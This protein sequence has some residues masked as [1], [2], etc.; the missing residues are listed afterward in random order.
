MKVDAVIKIEPLQEEN[1]QT[2]LADSKIII[3]K[4]EKV[5]YDVSSILFSP[6]G[7]KNVCTEAS[8]SSAHIEQDD[9]TPQK[10]VE[11]SLDSKEMPNEPTTV[12]LLTS[13][14]PENVLENKVPPKMVRATKPPKPKPNLPKRVHRIQT[15]RPS[16]VPPAKTPQPE[17][18]NESEGPTIII[19]KKEEPIAKKIIINS[20]KSDTESSDCCGFAT[21]SDELSIIKRYEF[22]KLEKTVESG[23]STSEIKA[24]E[25]PTPV[26][27]IESPPIPELPAKRN[28]RKSIVQQE[29]KIVEKPKSRVAPK[30]KSPDMAPEILTKPSKV[31]PKPSEVVPKPT[32]PVTKP[33]EAVAKPP[34]K[35]PA[36]SESNSWQNDILAVIGISRL[37]EI[38]EMLRNIPNMID[39]NF[40]PIEMENVELK[41]IIKHLLRKLKV[42]SITDT[43]SPGDTK[44][45][46]FSEG[47]SFCLLC[48]F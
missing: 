19:I 27:T 32:V 20:V 33:H 7:S 36:K 41:L 45:K 35:I 18:K 29:K 15:F 13:T 28:A 38:D 2:K 22:L 4:V 31:V 12:S 16:Q 30:V 34:V 25:K 26:V 6:G 42:E 40:N 8:C 46:V 9:A 1:E 48:N 39:G 37:K 44:P 47:L 11:I 24:E 43:L 10:S 23:V 3:Q 14:I 21:D 5:T 17:E